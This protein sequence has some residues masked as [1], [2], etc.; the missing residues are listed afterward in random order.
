MHHPPTIR[1]GNPVT[2]C[3]AVYCALGSCATA[4]GIAALGLATFSTIKTS[5]AHEPA[6]IYPVT[7]IA[8]PTSSGAVLLDHLAYDRASGTIWVPGSNT[9]KVFV[10]KDESDS[11]SVLTGFKTGPVEIEGQNATMGPTAVSIGE[12]VVYIGNRA[13][14]TLC[15]IDTGTLE[16]QNCVDVKRRSDIPDAGPHSVSYIAATREVWIATGPGKSIQVFD[17][18]D[19]KR[20]SWKM[21][22]TLEASC[23]GYAVDNARGRFYTNL[24]EIG[25]TVAFDVRSYKKVAEWNLGSHDVQGIALDPAR[26]L[27]FVACTDHVVSLDANRPN[28]LIDSVV[29]GA[30]LDDIAFSADKSVLYAAASVTATLAIIEVSNN[31]KFLLKALTPTAKSA[32]G[33]T[34]GQGDTAYVIDPKGGRILKVRSR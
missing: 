14:S 12:G 18:A 20:P 11:V 26:G 25:K 2:F 30:G 9:G 29:T 33:V 24:A 6:S 34:A 4:F 28:R 17:A 27:I 1:S 3:R 32:R 15:T 21:E 16:R 8:F 19:P 31:G 22:I 23:E 5:S 7:P 13:D 10:I